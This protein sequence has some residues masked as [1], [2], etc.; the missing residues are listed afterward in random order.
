MRAAFFADAERC[1]RVRFSAAL[2]AC[3]E[4]ALCDAAERGSFFNAFNLARERVG[5]VC[6]LERGCC[7]FS[8]SRC[9]L[10]RLF[11]E[12]LPRLGGGSFTPARRASERPM[13]IACFAERAPCFPWRMW[14]ISSR[15]NSPA[16]VEAGFPCALSLRAFLSVCFSG[17]MTPFKTNRRTASRARNLK[18]PTSQNLVG[19]MQMKNKRK[20]RRR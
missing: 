3:C 17:I 7:P 1:W 13:A 9:A 12:T 8:K 20:R 6:R 10:R 15:T 16:C 19:T 18:H 14:R 11:S 2:F 5:E 4:S